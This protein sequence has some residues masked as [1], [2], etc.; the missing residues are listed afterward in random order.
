MEVM[1][2]NGLSYRT[3]YRVGRAVQAGR[4]IAEVY[5]EFSIGTEAF[6]KAREGLRDVLPRL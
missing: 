3:R 2:I 6:K 1:K 4:I 5:N